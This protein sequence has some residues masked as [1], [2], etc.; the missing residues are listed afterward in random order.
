MSV[1]RMDSGFSFVQGRSLMITS[2]SWDAASFLKQIGDQPF[3][4]IVLAV[5]GR[6][7]PDAEAVAAALMAVPENGSATLSLDRE[8]GRVEAR[9]RPAPGG[10]LWERYGLRLEDCPRDGQ[11]VPTVVEVDA[12]SPAS[13]GRLL[14]RKQFEVAVFDFPLPTRDDPEYGQYFVGKVAETTQTGFSFGVVKFSPHVKDAISFLQFCTTREN[15]QAMNDI[16]Q[17]IPAIRGTEAT[18]YL[19]AFEPNYEGYWNWLNFGMGNRTNM[20]ES[21]AY[22]PYI[23]GDYTYEEYINRLRQTLPEAAAVDYQRMV[24]GAQESIPDKQVR[25]SM[26]L[27]QML[28]AEDERERGK[29]ERKYAESW[30]IVRTFETNPAMLTAQLA[31]SMRE[32]DNNEFSKAFFTV[33]D[34]IADK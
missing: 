10:D 19:K 1:D 21:Q 34:R 13:R 23:S 27:A 8:G 20:I 11:A 17:W 3:G 9:L 4:D 31:A 25:R 32:R 14:A 30:D 5:D 15:N 26:Y 33:Y 16:A 29:A 7:A 18:G 24:R 12:I 2:G 22:W 6:P 28:F